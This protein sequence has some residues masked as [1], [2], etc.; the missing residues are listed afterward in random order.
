MVRKFFGEPLIAVIGLRR[1]GKTSLILTALEEVTTPHL[2]IDL[3]GVVRS[4]RE[5]YKLLS[6]CLTDFLLRVSRIRGFY[7]YLQ[8]ILSIIKGV[9]VSGFNVEFSWG[10]E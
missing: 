7:E 6:Y 3:R 5:F 4:W 2:F 10:R 9:S 8:R 1:T